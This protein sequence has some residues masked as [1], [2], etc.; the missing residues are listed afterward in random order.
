M[1]EVNKSIFDDGNN[2]PDLP[3]RTG[4]IQQVHIRDL[5]EE[6][7]S[8]VENLCLGHFDYIGEF[9]AKKQRDPSSDLFSNVG[10]FFRPNYERGLL[11]NALI[12]K[13]KVKSYLEIGFGRGYSCFC[14]AMTMSQIEGG[15]VTTVDPALDENQLKSLS[16]IFPGEWF[17]K[18]NFIKATSDD[19]FKDSTEQFDMIYIDGDHRYEAVLK[20]WNNAKNCI[21]KIILFDDYH[22]PGKKQKDMDVSNVIDSIQDHEKRL[23][24]MDRRI[25]FDDRRV[26]DDDLD[27]GQVLIIKE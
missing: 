8:P 22:L 18:I 17:S 16:D 12:K 5:L 10:A 21:K 15:K 6:L 19:F 25:F 4:D 13:Y 7:D 9:T 27:Y 11:I 26:C 20:D 23:V 14:A 24:K 1:F 3:A 2:R